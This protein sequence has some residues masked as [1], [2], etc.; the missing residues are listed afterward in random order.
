MLGSTVLP[1]VSK[2]V[3]WVSGDAF[4]LVAGHQLF[5]IANSH[6]STDNLTNTRNKDIDTLSKVGSVVQRLHVEGLE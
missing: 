4:S 5:Q 6:T 1:L 3:V 2:P